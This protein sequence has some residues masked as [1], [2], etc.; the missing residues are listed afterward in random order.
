MTRENKLALVVG[1][2]LVLFVGILISD[3]FSTARQQQGADLLPIQDPLAS[4]DSREVYIPVTPP[5]NAS[6]G[7][8]AQAV[9][10]QEQ[11]RLDDARRRPPEQR[12]GADRN[13]VE[14]ELPDLHADDEVTGVIPGEVAHH[15]RKGETLTKVVRDHY[16]DATLVNDVARYNEIDDPNALRAG[17]RLRLPPR[18]ILRGGPPADAAPAAPAQKTYTVR[19]DDTLSDLAKRFLGSAGKWRRLYDANKDVIDNPDVLTPGITIRIPA[20]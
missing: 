20:G 5:E 3:H 12:A 19:D 6:P 4:A 15:L 11:R 9:E 2:G 17:R 8:A 13:G 14:I 16:G 7:M 1:F 10:R 18:H